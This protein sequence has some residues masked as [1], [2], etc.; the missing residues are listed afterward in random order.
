MKK[1]YQIELSNDSFR[2]LYLIL[3]RLLM[4]KTALRLFDIPKL[5]VSCLFFI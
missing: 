2:T 3:L 1:I 4:L 5:V